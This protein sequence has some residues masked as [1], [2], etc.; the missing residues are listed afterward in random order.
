MNDDADTALPIWTVYWN[1][2]DF[3]DR[4]V[5]RRCLVGRGFIRIDPEPTAVTETLDEARRAIPNGLVCLD[6][7]PRDDQVIVEVWV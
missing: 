2:K 6:R 7:D 3:R 5:V 4:Y 1:P